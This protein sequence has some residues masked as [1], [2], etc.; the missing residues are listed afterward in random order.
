VS[1]LQ[2]PILDTFGHVPHG[3]DSSERPWAKHPIGPTIGE[4]DYTKLVATIGAAFAGTAQPLPGQGNVT[5]WYLGDGFQTK[6]DPTKSRLYAGVEN[7]RGALP[8]WSNLAAKDRR[9]GRAPDQST[10]LADA[11]RIAYC[12][13]GVG[14]FFNFHLADEASL[15]GWQSGVLWADWTPKPSFAAFKRTVADIGARLVNCD[16]FTGNGAPPRPPAVVPQADLR[17]SG[18]HATSVGPGGATI[19]WR[20]SIPATTQVGYGAA[21]SGPTLFTTPRDSGLTHLATVGGLDFSTGYRIWVTATS[22]D[23]QR[24]RAALDVTTQ[25]PARS[26]NTTI[27]GSGRSLLVDGQPFFPLIVWSQCPDGYAADLAAGINLFADN[28]CGGLQNQLDSLGGRALSAAVAGKDG[29]NGP[30]LV[31]FFYTDEPDGLGLT[32]A[33]LPAR[34]GGNAGQIG[35]L[36]LTNHFYSGSAKLPW[37][38][39]YPGFVAKADMVGFDLYP[40]QDWCRADRL[41]DVYAAQ[42]ELI[43]LAA[44]RP[45]FQWIET[46][47]WQC[48][49]GPTAVTPATV[50]AESW[51]AI[52]AGAKGLG[53][54]PATFSPAIGGAIAALSHDVAKLGPALLTQP[55]AASADGVYVGARTYGR[56]TY[57]IAVNGSFRPVHATIRVSGLGT[58]VLHVYDEGRDV[59]S[60]ADT[61]TDDFA[62]LAVHVYIGPVQ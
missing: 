14:A 4:G 22:D 46:T 5:I 11:L 6:P 33:Q 35:F 25:A 43:R 19:S 20:T 39:D 12:Q 2:Q 44:P 16:A 42:Q 30:G 58:R 32:P 9:T 53:F 59:L 24:A 61:F 47:S 10:Q 13:P 41:G 27:G 34:P 54:F 60:S 26:P 3:V 15:A 37:A 49:N 55:T 48:P 8:A 17:I 52:A 38:V 45:T 28:P 7:D 29:G 62:P 21:A 50:R 1:G 18:L 51:L 40:L 57:V 36:T 23:G 31:G 56:T